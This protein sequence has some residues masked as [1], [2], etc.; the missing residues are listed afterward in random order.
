MTLTELPAQEQEFLQNERNS[1][2]GKIVKNDGWGFRA[3][4]ADGTRYFVA[5]R[6][7][8]G[9]Q[10]TKTG[11]S[12]P[13]GGGNYWEIRYGKLQFSR[14]SKQAPV[15]GK[16]VTL[17]WVD[18]TVYTSI[19]LDEGTPAEHVF[20]IPREVATKKDVLAFY[21]EFVKE[22]KRGFPELKKENTCEFASSV[23]QFFYEV[24]PAK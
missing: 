12:M 1:F 15:P 20:Y 2:K 13:F 5:T 10:D 8:V 14:R 6:Q 18:G 11:N 4:N 17:M 22:S 7:C 24:D 19:R 3:Y 21:K 16:D 9:W 23:G